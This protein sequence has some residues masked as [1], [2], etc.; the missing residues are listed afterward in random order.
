MKLVILDRDGVINHDSTEYI[1]SPD[2]W[3]ALPGS[4]MGIAELTQ[5][6]YTVT[7]ATNQSGIARG[8]Y[9]EATLAA[10]H[11]KMHDQVKA[12]GGHI[13]SIFY[14]PHG[15]WDECDCRK[16]AAGMFHQIAAHYECNLQGIPV[17]G[18]SYRDLEAGMSVGCTP[19]LVMTGNGR[20][21]LTQHEHCQDFAKA[22]DLRAVAHK[23]ITKS[24]S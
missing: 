4:L 5:A 18:D 16:P 14:C 8:L 20:R 21:T 3:H 19:W 11:A 23:L 7:V 17:V 9:D 15:P 24:S 13:D 22:D 1:K 6:G 10:I 2:E 12:E